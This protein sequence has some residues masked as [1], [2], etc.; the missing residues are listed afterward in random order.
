MSGSQGSP[1]Q[2][3]GHLARRY[4]NDVLPE[5]G[6][7]GIRL[8]AGR[9]GVRTAGLDEGIL[10]LSVKAGKKVASRSVLLRACNRMTFGLI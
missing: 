1:D 7:D 10:I 8:I 3:M 6:I 5:T 2:K 9:F 4:E